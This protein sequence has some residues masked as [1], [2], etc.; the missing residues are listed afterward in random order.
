M[1]KHSFGVWD[2]LILLNKWLCKSLAISW[3]IYS[4]I[5]LISRDGLD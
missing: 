1:K 5:Q 2:I 4:I 3:I